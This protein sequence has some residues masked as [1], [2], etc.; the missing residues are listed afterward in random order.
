MLKY[1]TSVLVIFKN[2]YNNSY[3]TNTQGYSEKRTQSYLKKYQNNF[4][5]LNKNY[6]NID[7]TY[8]LLHCH[9]FSIHNTIVQIIGP[10]NR[11]LIV[12][13]SLLL[14][15][16]LKSHVKL[17]VQTTNWRHFCWSNYLINQWPT[18]QLCILYHNLA[19]RCLDVLH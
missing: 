9:W 10:V 3:L 2:K 7:Y 13:V 12:W 17:Q 14:V 5:N 8:N 6:R 1:R 16:S 11:W 15:I 4:R 19:S 18:R